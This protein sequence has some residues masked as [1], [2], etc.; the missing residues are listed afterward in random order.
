MY[1]KSSTLLSIHCNAFWL[2]PY[3]KA[4]SLNALPLALD[5]NLCPST[6]GKALIPRA[7]FSGS[8]A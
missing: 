7:A 3:Q 5:M 8:L 1:Q 2:V 6:T 4:R